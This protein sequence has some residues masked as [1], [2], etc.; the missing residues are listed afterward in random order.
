MKTNKI[1]NF[2][3][4]VVIALIAASCVND[5]DYTIPE[6]LGTEEN[7]N[8]EELLNSGATEVTIAQLQNQFVSGSDATEI[9][10]D[11]YVKGYVSSS[12]ATGN[13]YKEFF[14][15]DAPQNPTAA[16][17]IALNQVDSYNQFNL[18]REVY[19][20][21]KGLYVGEM[22][23]GDGVTTIGGKETG[24]EVEN[25]T[26]NQ[27][28]LHVFRSTTTET[29]VPL[30]IKLAQITE[31]HIGMLVS[32]QNVEF[33]EAL[34]GLSYVNPTDDYETDLTIQSC[35]GFGYATFTLETSSFAN[36]K[37]EPLPM[38]GGTITG[39]IN[40][41]YNGSDLI[42]M[43]N[44]TDDV[45]LDGSRCSLLDPSDFSPIF[46]ETFETMTNN[47]FV[48]G[49]GWTNYAEAGTYKWK[50]K[51]TTDSGNSGSKVAWMGAYHSGSLVN[52]AWLISPAINLD[53][54]DLEFVNFES[55][56]DFADNS[57][58]ELLISTD[59]DGN[60]ATITSSTWTTLPGT[61]VSNSEFYQNWVDS[62]LI[63]LSSYSGTAYIAFRYIGG[64][65][66]ND[67]IDGNF[68]ID[69]FK[70]LVEN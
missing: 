23:S 8:L 19:V 52:I 41:T 38:G 2:I 39:V 43:L 59:W 30:N 61:I 51:T 27:I 21:L 31:A 20:S 6:S 17:K 5:D 16:I 50:I 70:V 67:T 33:P 53:A 28:P 58:L 14:I 26:A 66:A 56:N 69:N 3:S 11:I 54:Q 48:T 44:S 9:V 7:A 35:D 47:G 65:D 22:Y 24:G 49:N 13:F 57:K 32:S 37:Q 63:D 46:E 45:Q 25:M 64:D 4:V 15:Q 68:E 29:M 1:L 34:E 55:S 36:F 62:G 12:D 42:M 40:K 18:G 60:E 10:S